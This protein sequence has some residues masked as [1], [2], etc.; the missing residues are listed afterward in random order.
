M[1]RRIILSIGRDSSIGVVG[2][3]FYNRMQVYSA[4][5]TFIQIV[6]AVG[7][8]RELR[9]GDSSVYLTGGSNMATAFYKAFVKAWRLARTEKIDIVTTQD[10]L[11]AGLVGFLISRR[12]SLPLFVQ[13]HG[14]YLDNPLW[15]ASRVGTLNRVMN[16]VG[17]YILRRAASVRVVSARLRAQIITQFGLPDVRVRSI[18]IGTDLDIFAAV[19]HT[20]R[21]KRVLFVGRLLPEKEP[22]LFCAVAATILERQSDFTVGI[23]GE[24]FMRTEMETFFAN[25]GLLERC[26][27]YGNLELSAVAELYAT[28]F[29][30]IHTA[31]WEGWGM[32]MIEAMAAGCPV[33]TTDSG[34]A[35]EAIRHLD[36]GMVSPVGDKLALIAHAE[37]IIADTELWNAI[38]SNG[39]TESAIWSATNLTNKLMKWYESER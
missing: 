9:I 21:V 36:T 32:P 24:G 2:S 5:H 34:C 13:L 22:L 35:G 16:V 20:A 28:S 38:V 12:F 6:I 11:Y 7:T 33:V 4:S 25:K 3:P 26:H 8:P 23:A 31:S 37:A 1:S 15:F 10:V 17:K 19:S 29:C 39:R 27:F 18:P 30:Y 14:D